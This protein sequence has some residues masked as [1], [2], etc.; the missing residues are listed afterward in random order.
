MP[1]LLSFINILIKKI[2]AGQ[3]LV[4]G[5]MKEKI[6]RLNEQLNLIY[7]GHMVYQKKNNVEEIEKIMPQIQEFVLWFLGGNG[8]GI[9][10]ELYQDMSRNLLEILKDIAE[11]LENGDRVLLHDAAAY[12]L[13][14]YLR[15]F[16]PEQKEGIGG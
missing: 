12:G 15:L 10:E 11:A 14:E 2:N 8:F 6:E 16:L 3:E 5:I 7:I 4:D 9:E 13:S 1:A